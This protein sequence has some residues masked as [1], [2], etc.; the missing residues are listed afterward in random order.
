MVNLRMSE[1]FSSGTKKPDIFHHFLPPILESSQI[2]TKLASY[3]SIHKETQK[4]IN[5]LI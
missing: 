5:R 1:K 3:L 4:E 2:V